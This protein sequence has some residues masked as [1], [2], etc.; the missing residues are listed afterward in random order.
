MDDLLGHIRRNIGKIEISTIDGCKT[1]RPYLALRR[2]EGLYVL[3][4]NTFYLIK[5]TGEIAGNDG[6]RWT[7]LGK[8]TYG[9]LT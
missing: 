6:K 2:P 5:E 3:S 1:I 7:S 8:F 9:T 4:D